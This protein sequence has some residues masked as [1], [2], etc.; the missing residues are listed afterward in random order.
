M[1]AVKLRALMLL[2]GV[3]HGQRVQPELLAQHS[4]V[5]AVRV[6]QV[7]PDGDRLIGEVITDLDHGETLKLEPAV[8]V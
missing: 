3:F 5:I 4:Q 8:P 1:V 2:L 6:T 7:K